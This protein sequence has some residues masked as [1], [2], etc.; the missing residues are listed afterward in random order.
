MEMAADG[1]HYSLAFAIRQLEPEYNL[2]GQG[3]WPAPLPAK[4]MP[5]K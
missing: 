1:D 5:R 3:A 4:Y 2:Y